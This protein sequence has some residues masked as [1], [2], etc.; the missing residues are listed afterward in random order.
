[1]SHRGTPRCHRGTSRR[2]NA[3]VQTAPTQ[4][5]GPLVVMRRATET[6][7]PA[8]VETVRDTYAVYLMS[9]YLLFMEFKRKLL[10]TYVIYNFQIPY[11]HRLQISTIALIA[12]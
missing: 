3:Q 7:R 8:S 6:G 1:M 10:V 11:H 12:D 9:R 5:R 2:P 4:Q